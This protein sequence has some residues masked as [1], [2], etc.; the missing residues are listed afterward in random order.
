MR[1]PRIFGV[2]K[3]EVFCVPLR[4]LRQPGHDRC[5]DVDQRDGDAHQEEHW[6]HDVGDLRQLLA[7][8]ALRH[9]QVEACR[10]YALGHLDDAIG[11]IRG[12]MAT[13]VR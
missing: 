12:D 5:G 13:V 9:G 2:L 1:A 7:R 8:H 3:P 11:T 4:T 10:R 6:L